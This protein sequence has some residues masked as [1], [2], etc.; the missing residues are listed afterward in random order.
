MEEDLRVYLEKDHLL[1]ANKAL[2]KEV[3]RLTNERAATYSKGYQDGYKRGNQQGYD[4][5][6]DKGK[7]SH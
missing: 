6:Y 2:K 5:G 7:Y 4:K 3:D 1:K